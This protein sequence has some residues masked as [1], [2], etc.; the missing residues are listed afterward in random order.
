MGFFLNIECSK[1]I[2]ELHI[3]FSDG[4]SSV[5]ESKPKPE[6]AKPQKKNG[7]PAEPVK[8][9]VQSNE[10]LLDLESYDLPAEQKEIIEKPIISETKRNINVAKELQ[11]LDI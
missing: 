6:Q 9:K 11:N 2:D 4:S 7:K 10:P 1:D 5:V 8:K 3:N